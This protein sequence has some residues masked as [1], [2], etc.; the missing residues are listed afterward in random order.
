MTTPP[1]SLPYGNALKKILYEFENRIFFSKR[2]RDAAQD[3][4]GIRRSLTKDRRD[5]FHGG[6]AEGGRAGVNQLSN[7]KSAA[8]QPASRSEDHAR[9]S[10]TDL[11]NA[12]TPLR[13]AGSKDL[14]ST[15]NPPL[16]HHFGPDI[17]H[18]LRTKRNGCNST[19]RLGS[20]FAS[21]L[22]NHTVSSPIR[23]KPAVKREA[24]PE[25][26]CP[27]PQSLPAKRGVKS[28]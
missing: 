13:C 24:C 9:P 23:S 19:C 16:H 10:S 28:W 8:D 6:V 17:T 14:P 20:L 25:R 27:A 22:L 26:I 3:W 11:P 2:G 4:L 5:L 15:T 1:V 21:Q 18:Q 7:H 12:A